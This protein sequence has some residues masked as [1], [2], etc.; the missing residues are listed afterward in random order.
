MK[1]QLKLQAILLRRQGL[2]YSE[3]LKRVRVAKSTLS[4]WLHSVDLSQP[5][6]QRLT[7]KRLK[8]ALRGAKARKEK[9][10]ATVRAIALQTSSDVKKITNN[11]LFFMGIMLYWAEGAKSKEHNPSQGVIFSNSDPLMVKLF[12]KWLKDVLGISE[13]R[14]IFEIYVHDTY[15]ERVD[16]F[17]NYWANVTGFP[18]QK[19]D[20]IYFKKHKVKSNRKN[21]KDGY[22]GLLRVR[23][24]KSTNLNR[25]ISRWIQAIS[26]QCGV[27]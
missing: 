10:L 8:A 23:I 17:K 11:E 3:I 4:L 15:K 20:R 1:R 13:E 27:V 5:Q 12:L 21:I 14:L 9:R 22:K 24:S 7:E 6:K 2:S 26:R 18:H 16:K 19:F 25:K